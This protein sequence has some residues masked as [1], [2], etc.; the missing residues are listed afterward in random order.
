VL[1][2][3][4]TGRMVTAELKAHEHELTKKGAQVSIALPNRCSWPPS[5]G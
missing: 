3:T 1:T 5:A 2:F 4:A